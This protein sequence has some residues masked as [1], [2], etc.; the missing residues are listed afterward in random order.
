MARAFDGGALDRC[1]GGDA[2][3]FSSGGEDRV[4]CADGIVDFAVV[5]DLS[6]S[7]ASCDFTEVAC[8]GMV[9]AAIWDL[10]AE[11]EQNL[12]EFA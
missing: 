1:I 8:G 9:D 4:Q 2:F 5:R 7:A 6:R 12:A 11:C 3:E 10:F